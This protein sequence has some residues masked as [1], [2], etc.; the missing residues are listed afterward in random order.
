MN[1]RTL[2]SQI[3]LYSLLCA[4]L[5]NLDIYCVHA[6]ETP[7]IDVLQLPVTSKTSDRLRL[8]CIIDLL[9]RS[10]Q[11]GEED[12]MIGR[13]E[14][15]PARALVHDVQQEHP[16]LAIVLEFLKILAL[17]GRGALDFEKSNLVCLQSLRDLGSQVG[18]LD[19][20]ESALVLGDL[21]PVR[22]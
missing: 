22:R 11:W 21:V 17:D 9:R 12:R 2:S 5:V 15:C 19:E 10:Q 6:E 1:A 7:D 8:A 16:L 4:L 14:V 3:L 13:R 20:D 18:K